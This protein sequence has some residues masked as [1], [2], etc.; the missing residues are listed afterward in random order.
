LPGI[1]ARDVELAADGL[2]GLEQRDRMAA[3][4]R[5]DGEGQ[6]RRAGAHHG[7]G[8]C[9]VAAGSIASSVSWQARGFTRQE[10]ILPLKVWSRQAWLQAMQVLISSARPSAALRTNSASARKGRAIDTMS[11]AFGQ[12]ALGHLGRVDAVGGHQRDAHLAHQRWR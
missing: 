5:R 2:A 11:A 6:P 9:G 8:A 7:D 12:Q 10:V 3:L 1:C 4:R